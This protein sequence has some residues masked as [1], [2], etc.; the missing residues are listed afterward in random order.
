M[1]LK[2][3]ST[4]D[5]VE[6]V[7]ESVAEKD[8]DFLAKEK[9]GLYKFDWS[10]FREKEVY[11]L[12]LKQDQKILGLMSITDHSETTVNAIEIELLEISSDNL[13]SK[14]LFDNIAGCLIAFA[15]SES[16]RRSHDG[17]V[18]L[19]PKTGLIEHYRTRYGFVLWPIKTIYRPTGIMILGQMA[20]QHLIATFL[21]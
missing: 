14:K 13:G 20:S 4:G 11:K 21:K 12:R 3:A 8:F 2:N 10:R 9:N 17:F 6:A 7:I 19:T 1:L 15:C 5:T 18:F 16:F